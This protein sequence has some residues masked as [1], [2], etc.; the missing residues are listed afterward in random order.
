MSDKH[1]PSRHT[2]LLMILTL[3]GFALRLFHLG[4]QSYWLDEAI[5]L[6]IARSD[7]ATILTNVVQSSH[8]PLYYLLLKGWLAVGLGGDETTVRLLSALLSTAAI[9]AVYVLINTLTD[10]RTSLI[11]AAFLAVM[12]FQVL[13]AQE[14][15][16]Y[17]LLVLLTTLTLWAFVRAW[18]QNRWYN[19]LLF[20]ITMAACLYT[21]YFSFLVLGG[22]GLFA[23]LESLSSRKRDRWPGMVLSGIVLILLFAPQIP[24]L[25]DKAGNAMGTR[26][27]EPNYLFFFT[28]LYFLLL[29][30]TVSEAVPFAA[31]AMFIT[32]FVVLLVLWRTSRTAW[33]LQSAREGSGARVRQATLFALC[34]AIAP[35]VVLA[36]LLV[37]EP[38]WIPERTLTIV[39]PAY[40]LLLALGLARRPNKSPLTVLYGLLAVLMIV[41]LANYYLDPAY[42]KP[43][44]RQAAGWIAERYGA[45]DIEV[46]TSDGSYLPFLQYPRS[47]VTYLLQGDP[48]AR[49]PGP[50]YG[51]L[52]GQTISRDAV[53]AH[54][55][56]IWLVVAL[57]H[58]VDYQLAVQAWLQQQYSG[59]VEY[60]LRGIKIYLLDPEVQD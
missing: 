44:Y 56:R 35:L 47:V 20:A 7:L 57:E 28:T 18:Q 10:Q 8:P 43:P 17:G 36:I 34:T 23:L 49:K 54:E 29:S 16:M 53:L 21:H 6:G 26:W 52:G 5:S 33:R 14:A 31:A 19:W 3:L 27:V 25:L 38:F 42:A 15:R 45:D 58:S 55:G 39:T 1:R 30:Y 12:P 46:H 22:L 51:V 32:F 2:A 24:L 40:A 41:S 50:V 11:G 60:D 48:D 59:V 37:V 9:P 4:S 13:Y